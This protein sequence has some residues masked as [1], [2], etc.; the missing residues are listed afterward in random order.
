M[1][2]N[3]EPVDT[4]ASEDTAVSPEA[5]VD[6][7][8]DTGADT[9]AGAGAG[10][11]NTATPPFNGWSSDGSYRFVPPRTPENSATPPA[12]GYT[13]PAGN[14]GYTPPTGGSYTPPA[15]GYYTPPYQPPVYG[16]PGG[17]QP[18]QKPRK[19]HNGWIVA[20]A[21]IAAV[22][23]IASVVLLALAVVF[24][25]IAFA[26]RIVSLAS[27]TVAVLYPIFTGLYSWYA[28]R[29]ILFTTLCALIMGV[30]VIWMHRANIQR[31]MNGTEYRFGEKKK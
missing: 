23:L 2:D 6:E 27:V 9:A 10:T 20:I 29:D 31:L 19:K 15:G 28:G 3:T 1:Q 8:A 12:G 11:D 7:S 22:C 24:F 4:P 30:L 21:I 17:S 18:P 14:A 5:P 13:S 16:A 25:S 26:S